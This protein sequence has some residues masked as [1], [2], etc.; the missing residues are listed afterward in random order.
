M[1]Q[2]L[3]LL[4]LIFSVGSLFSQTTVNFDNASNW[5]QGSTSFTSYSNHSYEI[6]EATFQGENVIRNATTAQDGFPGAYGT[7]SFRVRDATSKLTATII[8]GGVGEFSFKV[9]RWDG[10]P[11]T[12]YTV[13]YSIN[14]GADWI[15]LD[16]INNTLLSTSDWFTYTETINNA[17]SNILIEIARVAGERIMVDD[18]SW[19]SFSGGGNISP[20]ITNILTSP[21]IVTPADQVLVSADV[22]DSDGTITGVVLNW[23]TASGSLTNVIPMVLL[24]KGTYSIQ[25]AIP[26][27]IDGTQ[28][29]YQ[30]SATDNLAANTLSSIGNYTV[31]APASQLAF[32]N[33]PG[34]GQVAI[35][36]NSFNVEAR[37]PNNEVDINYN[38][39][40]TIAEATA[41]G[42]LTGTLAVTAVNGIATFSNVIFNESGNFSLVATATGL[43]SAT[44]SGIQISSGPTLTE[45]ILP[46]YIQGINGTNND[47]VPYAYRV[48][49]DNLIPNA[50]YR[51]INQVV[52]PSD[53]STSNGAGNVIFVNSNGTFTRSSGPSLSSN[54]NY[55]E[56]LTDNTGS[57]TG[58]F[59]TEPTGNATRFVPGNSLHMRIILN[60]GAGGT[61]VVN[62][63]TTSN[64][65]TVINFGTT[66]S[67][68][69]GTGIYGLTNFEPFN[70]TFLYG[71]TFGTGRPLTG[72]FVEND[73][74]TGGT[75][76]S[77]FYR[78]N[79]EA[80]NGRWGAIVP[81]IN[82][83]GVKFIEERKLSD[84]T[85]A[86]SRSSFNGI[87]G[88]TD[89]KNPTGGTTP[90]VIDFLEVPTLSV[91]PTS[92]QGF[93]YVEGQGPSA[94]QSFVLT[95]N[96]LTEVVFV[97][98]SANYEIS[99]ANSPG[100][101]PSN[102]ITLVPE[103]GSIPTTTIY[104]RLKAGLT[105]GAYSNELIF[106]ASNGLPTQSVVLSGEVTGGVT[107]PLAHVTNFAATSGSYQ[108]VTLSWVDAV[109]S[110]TSYLIKGSSV[111]YSA[112]SDPVEGVAEGNGP[113]VQNVNNGIQTF[114][115][116]GL[117]GS[118]T[119]YFKI[120]P[121]NGTGNLVKYKKDGGVPQ[122]SAVTPQG[123]ELTELILP[124]TIQGFSGTNNYRI[125]Y[126]FR[127]R[128]SGLLPNATY[129][130]IN[131]AV[132]T[133]DGSTGSG[134]G[135]PIF[136]NSDGTFLRATGASFTNATQH[137]E[138][139]TDATGSYTGWFMLE[140]TG[141]SRFTPGS[142]LNMRIRLNNGAG[143]TTAVHYFTSQ[144][145]Q[146]IGFGE[147][148][149]TASGTGIR[150]ISDF[151]SKNFVFLY[152]AN[153]R[154]SRPIAGTSI[155]TTGIDFS[156]ITAYPAFYRNDVSGVN[157]SFGTIIPNVN[158]S[159]IQRIEEISLSTGNLVATR[160]SSNGI[161][162]E[163]QTVNPV[164]GLTSI[165]VLNLDLTPTISLS[166]T[167]LS[168]FEY[169][170]GF[171]PSTEQSFVLTASNLLAPVIINS[172]SSFEISLGFGTQ[173][174]PQNT[175]SINPASG[176]VASTVIYL[177]LK[178]GKLEGVYAE[179]LNIT[180]AGAT[181]KT[182]NLNGIVRAP[183]T[184]PETHISALSV[185]ILS[186]T[187]LNVSW[188]DAIPNAQS[189]L[190]KASADGFSDI[191]A[192]VD[193]IPEADGLLV[194]NVVAGVQSVGFT[195]LNPE[196]GYYFKVFPYNGNGQTINFKV[197]GDVPMASA[198]TL[199]EP[200][201]SNLLVPKFMQGINGTNNNRVPYAF[202]VSLNNLKPNTTFKYINQVV[203]IADGPESSGAGNPVYVNGT[204]FFRSSNPGFVNAGQYGQLTTDAFGAYSGWFIV[205][206][207][208]NERFTPGNTVFMRIRLNDGMGGNVAV[209]FFTSEGVTVLGFGS[210]ANEVSGTA[211]MANSD[212]GPKN[213][214]FIYENADG[215][216]RP[217]YGTS[218]ETSGVDYATNESYAD[219]YRNL[220]AES[221]G[222]WGGIVPN[223]N[224]FGVRR[225]E[226]RSLT[227]GNIIS[228]KNSE[229]GFWGATNT[230]NPSGGL[231]NILLLDLMQG[232]QVEK[233]AG[234]LKYFNAEETIIS[235][236]FDNTSFYVQLFENGVPVRPRQLIK[237]NTVVNLPSYFEFNNLEAG[238]QYSLRIWE[239]SQ[240]N[241][242]EDTWSWKNWG[243]I[244]ANDALIINYMAVENPVVEA[245]P[246]VLSNEG[247]L[248]PFALTIADVNNSA[249]ISAL[250]ALTLMYK[251]VGLP[252]LS[253]FPDGKTNFQFSGETLAGFDDIVYPHAPSVVFTPFGLYGEGQPSTGVYYESL[254]PQINVGLNVFNIYMSA[255]GDI[256]ASYVPNA[257]N[258]AT[259]KLHEDGKLKVSVGQRIQIPVV[260]E[261]NIEVS[262]LTMNLGFDNS[263]LDVHDVEGIEIKHI[264]N[265]D[266]TIRTAWFANQPLE[267]KAGQ[268]ILII[269][270]TIKAEINDSKQLIWLMNGV[271]FGDVAGTI[272]HD[273]ALK[274][275]S[276]FTSEDG[277][278]N[279]QN[280]L[281]STLYP[282]PMKDAGTLQL[283]LPEAGS[284]EI[285]I[286]N[287]LGQNVHSVVSKQAQAGMQLFTL[288][289]EMVPSNGIYF[290]KVNLKGVT[291][292]YQ[293]QKRFVV[294][295]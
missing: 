12:N 62:R 238:R 173:F 2:K 25:S 153:E 294:T 222:S 127:M 158:A 220:V 23:G 140:P 80:L 35:Q 94:V 156:S 202:R 16:P 104:V 240:T 147:T 14:D 65:A 159:G 207:T 293:L 226:E 27:Q 38:G 190:V 184:E 219:F 152:G 56:F 54:G 79:V 93:S 250:D 218:I 169:P 252:G 188:T 216:G 289:N 44:S 213:F 185:S 120:F 163:T 262:A 236:P 187:A 136:V 143:G 189:Y 22:T 52:I 9:R 82:N 178:A 235:T 145:I 74:T 287:Q 36:L 3:L 15:D 278:V 161:W 261:N 267:I 76:Y 84:G 241:R 111:G 33:V 150:A 256:N 258:K 148:S 61:T 279:T 176:V 253:T 155:E 1:R 270:A 183:I 276:Y 29:F 59:I 91:N 126:A 130:Y 247:N 89:T 268:S 208:G 121:Y 170:Q 168:G 249:G 47:R 135:N 166:T 7:Y 281:T 210:E 212:A 255:T 109:P 260:V 248:T 72:T 239:Q 205:E 18:F 233:I 288:E 193:G 223:L 96:N 75:A 151:D 30:I 107:T 214:A 232:T 245:F 53:P 49:I 71:N 118:S 141:N 225:V 263:I 246:W 277:S 283:N 8:S 28:I 142:L 70:F 40:I 17:A 164:G 131:Q 211:I 92:L 264:N 55:G 206:P 103:S 295:P 275:P 114:T 217:L 174:V 203:Q 86:S 291:K 88:A 46:Q 66:S 20:S 42:L 123:P 144:D 273:V 282:N 83:D 68:T 102:M 39:E 134:A 100:F 231:S 254:L 4:F 199:G 97:A 179:I 50:T 181:A 265:S 242:I 285:L 230:T 81:N 6:A 57:F 128:F 237:H 177:R 165:L 78:N 37:K 162:G 26:A 224:I 129:K 112:I 194:K 182:I 167:A 251:L 106:I 34:F 45:I 90:L 132:N 284:L 24:G 196:T 85:I 73:G 234:Q 124:L 105:S 286:Y 244:S 274:S 19:N 99:L 215:S 31:S 221:N 227:T 180:S 21:Q 192:P 5:V 133:S 269:D 266:G 209:Q 32:T 51:Y 186:K 191:L 197:D 63:L 201:L 69:L 290:Y 171:G 48:R 137:A 292:S 10:N 172:T 119:Y 157:G 117:T 122:A 98:P 13:K 116:N 115:F 108:S 175:I 87:W 280:E 146:V 229:D 139:L 58:W 125:P 271:E 11:P 228:S 154:S 77:L 259:E 198:T 138:F 43:N 195:N 101:V 60:N 110:A 113:L 41:S 160:T 64:F 95:G 243:G 204:N 257:Q 67:A 200:S 149:N 272:L